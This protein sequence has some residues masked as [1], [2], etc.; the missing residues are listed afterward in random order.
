[1]ERPWLFTGNPFESATSNSY[2]RAFMIGNFTESVLLARS[3]SATEIAALEIYFKPY[4][5]AYKGVY[6][7]WR[8]QS[9][10]QKMASSSLAQVLD[11]GPEHLD[12][13]S[14]TLMV[15]GI[16][17]GMPQF[18]RVFPQGR[19]PFYRGHQDSR[20][21]A[22]QSLEAA[23]TDIGQP[24]LALEAND[25]YIKLHDANVFQEGAKGNTS[26]DSNAT[27]N[28][29][30]DLCN[31]LY[32]VL[33][34]LMQYYN[35]NRDAISSYFLLRL[36]RISSQK[37][38]VG[39]TKPSASYNIAKRTLEPESMLTLYNGGVGP[40]QFWLA[41]DKTGNNPGGTPITIAGGAN[42]D[43]TASQLGDTNLSTY[44]MVRNPDTMQEG[45]W[46]VDL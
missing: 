24:A 43:V 33:G 16:R 13:W 8:G 40:L 27:E 46:E 2:I 38:F 18:L 39:H 28:G 32:Y 10:A 45:V 44:L 11:D 37:V 20:I 17:P 34:G 19:S 1:M 12:S 6:D 26:S 14:A 23:F 15:A 35:T 9:G 29:R 42:Q 21:E 5:A 3:A 4:W 22:Y 30:I 36:I 31:A 7:S 25:F 41:G